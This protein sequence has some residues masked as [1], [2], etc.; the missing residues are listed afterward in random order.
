MATKDSIRPAVDY[1]GHPCQVAEAREQFSE[2]V[3]NAQTLA[4][5][6]PREI[7]RQIGRHLNCLNERICQ[8][9]DALCVAA[10]SLQSDGTV[11]GARA[12]LAM[13]HEHAVGTAN[14]FYEFAGLVL[15]SLD[16]QV[17]E[18]LTNG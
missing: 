2:P 6:E 16:K 15:V 1:L 3:S 13:A 4:A 5:R 17:A 7:A 9:D 8:L 10:N 14:E 18:G 12:V 11:D